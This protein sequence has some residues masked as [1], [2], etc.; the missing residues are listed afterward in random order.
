MIFELSSPVFIHGTEIPQVYTCDG[1]DISPP[2]HWKGEPEGTKSFALVVDDPDAPVGTWDH[3]ILFNIP[4]QRHELPE[5]M[6]GVK[7]LPDNIQWGKTSWGIG[8]YG[9]PCPPDKRHRY[10]FTL[11]ALD[12]VLTLSNGVDKQGLEAEIAKHK[13]GQAV[14]MGTYDRPR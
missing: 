13:L 10:F 5:G 9:G 1:Q 7:N 2:L 6:K 4:V 3:W 14:L 8:D 11:Y 12:A